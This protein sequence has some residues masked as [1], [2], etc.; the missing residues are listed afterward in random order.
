MAKGYIKCEE[1]SYFYGPLA[2]LFGVLEFTPPTL[3]ETRDWMTPEI[4]KDLN[5]KTNED[6]KNDQH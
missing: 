1:G 4:D 3:Q 6:L 5:I 2:K